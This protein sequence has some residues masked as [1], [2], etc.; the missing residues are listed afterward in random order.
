MGVKA[1]EDF[2]IFTFVSNFFGLF[3]TTSNSVR[4]TMSCHGSLGC[5]RCFSKYDRKKN[6]STESVEKGGKSANQKAS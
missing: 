2:W 1:C 5:S 3:G 4:Q 6:P